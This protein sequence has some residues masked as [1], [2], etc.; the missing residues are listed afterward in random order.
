LPLDPNSKLKAEVHL[1][2]DPPAGSTL[3]AEAVDVWG[4]IVARTEH[5]TNGAKRISLDFT[6]GRLLGRLVSLLITLADQG[7]AP[8]HFV[9]QP[10][11]IANTDDFKDVP[12]VSTKGGA[13]PQIWKDF[14]P[15]YAGNF[16]G[17]GSRDYAL[18][19]LE[20]GVDLGTLWTFHDTHPND[21]GGDERSP[22]LTS[23]PFLLGLEK[24]IQTIAASA[25][26]YDPRFFIL[27]DETGPGGGCLSVSCLR[28]FRLFLRREYGTLKELN[29]IWK[30]SYQN[31][32]DVMPQQKAAP[33]NPAAWLDY[34][35]FRNRVYTGF[36][37]RE[38]TLLSSYIPRAMAGVGSTGCGD[39]WLYAQRRRLSLLRYGFI[40]DHCHSSFKP[41][42]QF[43]CA[44]IRG[45]HDEA[46]TWF[47][48][49]DQ[50]LHG[51]SGIITWFKVGHPSMIRSDRTP[52]P[53]M[54]NIRSVADDLQSGYGR[55][56]LGARRR[57]NDF[58][59]Y[60][61]PRSNCMNQ[62]EKKHVNVANWLRVIERIYRYPRFIA[63]AEVEMG[64][65]RETPP[66]ILYLPRVSS[67]S[68]R[69]IEAVKHYVREG[70]VLLAGLDPGVHDEHGLLR[71]PWPLAEVFGI[72][73]VP[74][75]RAP[76]AN[77]TPVSVKIT[78]VVEKINLRDLEMTI[79]SDKVGA[80]IRSDG[81]RPLFLIGDQSAGFVNRH[82]KGLAVYFNLD[83]MDL[84]MPKNGGVDAGRTAVQFITERIFSARSLRRGYEIHW[85]HGNPQFTVRRGWPPE[86]GAV[87]AEF[88]DPQ[89]RYI[90]FLRNGKG[91]L[92]DQPQE[93]ATLALDEPAHV[94]EPRASRYAGKV[95]KVSLH[96]KRGMPH[97]VSLLPYAVRTVDVK[98]P[99]GAKRGANATIHV[100]IAAIVDGK[101]T[102]AGRH[103][104]ALRVYQPAG[105][106]ARWF[107]KNYDTPH[108]RLKTT[109]PIA[110]NA[111][112]GKWSVTV[113][114]VATGIRGK[115][116]FQV[117]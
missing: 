68:D 47:L 2:G 116:E 64:F 11:V 38:Q 59:V 53:G 92:V 22:C 85:E 113:R 17:K 90:V 109:I 65:L 26:P 83:V 89:A 96:F 84:A 80:D 72:K 49:W 117:R 16:P 15:V 52:G 63:Y 101:N 35:T 81:A 56:F 98:V 5:A 41:K 103:V 1:T 88:V 107:R 110:L 25:A 105:S 43:Y 28:R 36:F 13:Y 114:D 97:I 112:T 50:V 104:L 57:A 6:H 60:Y 55:L 45:E 14:A 73:R 87:V 44:Y 108:G 99:G 12:W 54:R 27:G 8:L 94:Y 29:K 24:K 75:R 31:W 37:D 74:E 69:E 4:R 76:A 33:G 3:K 40:F 51:A 10:V 91:R 93:E 106:E 70:G 115:V 48:V 23:L 78:G 42:D 19:S 66:K 9:K 95:K 32:D 58:A 34:R 100:D 30:R 79:Q 7:G 86:Q 39:E 111:P 62:L 82:G 77:A 18:E 102:S 67:L 71:K 20:A 46:E 61:S 21:A